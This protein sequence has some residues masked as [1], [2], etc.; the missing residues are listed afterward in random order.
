MNCNLEKKIKKFQKVVDNRVYMTYNTTCVTG[1]TQTDTAP[2]CGS[3][4]LER[5]VWD[6]EV[7]GSNPVTPIQQLIYMR[8]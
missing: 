7:A 4:W 5:L 6:Q 1:V 2:G 3:A 8:V